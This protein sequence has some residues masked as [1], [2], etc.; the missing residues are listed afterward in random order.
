MKFLNKYKNS[1]ILSDNLVYKEK[2]DNTVLRERLLIE[3]Y[4]FCAYSEYA[5]S[6]RGRYHIN[7]VDVEH[8]DAKLKGTSEDNYYN[9]YAVLAKI[10]TKK[11]DVRY[12]N[13]EFHKTK[14]YQNSANFHSR[15]GLDVN[16]LVYY[17]LDEEDQEAKDFIDFIMLNDSSLV[18][19]RKK[20]ISKLEMIYALYDNVETDFINFLKTHPQELSFIS[21]IEGHFDLDLSFAYSS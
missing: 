13:N 2:G 5:I 3:Q 9:W 14:F 8:F 10:N 16:D 1:P 19:E 15:I 17:P 18:D 21:C 7:A 11:K 20:H 6:E 12:K 4:Y